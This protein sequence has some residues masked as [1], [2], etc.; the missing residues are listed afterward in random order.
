MVHGMI[1]MSG[2]P[3][4]AFLKKFHDIFCKI[5]KST[6]NWEDGRKFHVVFFIMKRFLITHLLQSWKGENMPVIAGRLISK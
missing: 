4:V 5:I 1:C 6:L 3:G 2:Q